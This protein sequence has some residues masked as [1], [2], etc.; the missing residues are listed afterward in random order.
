MYLFTRVN[1]DDEHKVWSIKGNCS[2]GI[3]NVF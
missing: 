2:A 3:E 1:A